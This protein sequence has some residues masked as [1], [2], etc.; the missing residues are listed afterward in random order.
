MSAHNKPSCYRKPEIF[1]MPP[2]VVLWL[3]FI[4]SNYPSLEHIFM[5]LQVFEPLN[6]YCINLQTLLF[7]S[8]DEV[9]V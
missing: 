3:T 6:F 5:V 7:V 8:L 2:D 9:A 4:S 1:I